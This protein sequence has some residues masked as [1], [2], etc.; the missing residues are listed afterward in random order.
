MRGMGLKVGHPA[1][2]NELGEGEGEWQGGDLLSGMQGDELSGGYAL[3]W[4]V[5]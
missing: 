4:A 5:G 2:A 1:T 3:L